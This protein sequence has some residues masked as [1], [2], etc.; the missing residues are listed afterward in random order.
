MTET[1]VIAVDPGVTE[2]TA[3]MV[4]LS[5]G[6]VIDVQKISKTIGRSVQS[7]L[8]AVKQV[9]T[10]IGQ[11]LEIKGGAAVTVY[12]LEMTMPHHRWSVVAM[13][14]EGDRMVQRAVL[15]GF[16]SLRAAKVA[17]KRQ[18]GHLYLSYDLPTAVG[19]ARSVKLS[20]AMED[21]ARSVGISTDVLQALVDSEA[22]VD[23]LHGRRTAVSMG[24][25][26][27]DSACSLCGTPTGQCAHT[28]SKVNHDPYSIYLLTQPGE[29]NAAD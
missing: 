7:L 8:D 25:R 23:S 22:G 3:A 20:P 16:R 1:K 19:A 26:V 21:H 14:R 12:H 27:L 13:G 28:K 4:T 10:Q 9:T 18:I 29:E 24:A 15:T 17:G 5:N 6:R 11:G 2:S